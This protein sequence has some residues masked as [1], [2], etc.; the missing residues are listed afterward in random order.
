MVWAGCAPYHSCHAGS[1]RGR[2]PTVE[3]VTDPLPDSPARDK[4]DPGVSN[5]VLSYVPPAGVRWGVS[6]AAMGIAIFLTVLGLVA[7]IASRL[8][9]EYAELANFLFNI[10]V[11]G[12]LAGTAV[13]A[14]RLR[15]LK[16]L[17]ADF[18]M[19]LKWVDLLW[20]ILIGIGAKFLVIAFTGVAVLVT[21]AAPVGGNFTLSGDTL[22]IVLNGL[23]FASLLA[24]IVEELFMRG[25]LLRAVR[26]SV[27]HGWPRRRPQPAARSIQITAIVVSVG[28]SSFIFTLLHLW[29][30]T[31]PALLIV[32]GLSTFTLGVVN[33]L[34]AIGTGRIGAPIVAHVVYNGSSVVLLLLSRS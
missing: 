19:R 22:W 12:A 23:V 1:L 10:V 34:V 17:S 21:G 3:T 18:G 26:N 33:G 6:E 20:G 4:S 29:Q 7:A 9:G 28:V 11:Y 2:A 30:S 24:P 15:G 8:P 27:L 14:S 5:S 31:D 16:S 13:V 32:L 25:L